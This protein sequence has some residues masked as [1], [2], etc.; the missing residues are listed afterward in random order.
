MGLDEA[1][2]ANLSSNPYLISCFAA[3]ARPDENFELVGKTVI[4][5]IE[6]TEDR[7]THP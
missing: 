6:M 2:L 4:S 1:T 7:K 3:L 5:L